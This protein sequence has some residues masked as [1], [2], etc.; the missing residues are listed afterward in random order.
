MSTRQVI[1]LYAQLEPPQ[2]QPIATLAMIGVWCLVFTGYLGYSGYLAFAENQ[3][4]SQL[5]KQTGLNKQLQF[6][7]NQKQQADELIDL[8]QFE[9]SLTAL[10]HRQQ[11]LQMLLEYLQN[12][13]IDA[14]GNF[15]EAMAALARQH[16][17]GV[18]LERFSFVSQG[19]AV[20]LSGA[21]GHPEVLPQYVRR[22]GTER[23]FSDLRFNRVLM[24]AENEV[25]TFE[26][27]SRPSRETEE[28]QGS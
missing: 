11:R 9:N 27:S 20:S 25:L 12:A 14:Q 16:I 10:R 18:A 17:P 28:G 26:M 13:E 23:A 3:L 6:E 2:E 4:T 21:L 1:N 5:A 24:K 19:N 8:A 7:I 15:S 22:L